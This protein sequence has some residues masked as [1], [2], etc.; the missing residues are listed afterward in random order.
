MKP[1]EF[2]RRRPE[3]RENARRQPPRRPRRAAAKRDAASESL[4]WSRG[5]GEERKGAQALVGAAPVD[6]RRRNRRKPNV[7]RFLLRTLLVLLVAECAAVLLFSPRLWVRTLRVEGNHT[8]SAARI[9]ERTGLRPQTNLVSLRTGGIRARVEREP[10]I[11]HAEV[12]RQ[13]PDTLT[14]RVREREPWVVVKTNGVFYT[15]DETLVP[16]HK[17]RMPPPGLPIIVLPDGSESAPRLGKQI[18]TRGVQTAKKCLLWAEVQPQFPLASITVDRSGKLCLN[19]KGGGEVQLGTGKDLDKK[20]N[21]LALLLEQ[22]PD[23][24]SGNFA[25][26][27]LYAYDAPALY[28]RA[29]TRDASASPSSPESGPAAADRQDR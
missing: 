11:A 29:E 18:Q 26:V 14:V 4:V 23:V 8:V 10:A 25:Y 21:A 9:F 22:R 12:S 20:L 27:N 5:G 2:L 15:A 19:R 28:P 13:L 3:N 1:D 16:F 24:R 6:P 7:A 17:D